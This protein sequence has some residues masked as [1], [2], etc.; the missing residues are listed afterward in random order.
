VS[1]AKTSKATPRKR[2][3][4][5]LPQLRLRSLLLLAVVS[6]V[7]LGAATLLLW[8][9]RHVPVL[10]AEALHSKVAPGVSIFQPS[11]G[12]QYIVIKVRL[13]HH[14]AHELWLAPVTQSYIKDAH[15]QQYH[16]APYAL[17]TPFNAGSYAPNQTVEGELSYQVSSSATDLQWCYKLSAQQ[18]L[19]KA[20]T[21]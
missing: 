9:R 8:H 20:I 3:F 7:V 12:N 19:C 16:M 15:G 21:P 14:A 1:S 11:P 17:E 10:T 6:Y 18:P 2:P 13:S 4:L 5:K